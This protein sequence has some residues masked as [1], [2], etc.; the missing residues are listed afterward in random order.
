MSSA[1]KQYAD[2]IFQLARETQQVD[3]INADLS[4]LADMWQNRGLRRMLGHPGLPVAGKVDAIRNMMPPETSELTFNLLS[5]LVSRG[6]E[7]LLQDIAQ[8]VSEMADAAGGLIHAQVFS[9]APQSADALEMVR[10][11][12]QTEWGREVRVSGVVDADLL[13]G[14]AVKV[15]DQWIDG[16]L[17]A[18]LDKL[19]RELAGY[20]S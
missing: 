16:S 13:G 3:S 11:R 6:R 20:R 18:Q 9:A 7:G 17:A 2:A 4:L 8:E 10:Q 19:R 1:G 14:M 12:L 15:G 5:L